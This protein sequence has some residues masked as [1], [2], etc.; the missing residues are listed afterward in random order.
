MNRLHLLALLSTMLAP[1]LTWAQT[2][3]APP[4][5][6]ATAK[7]DA[8]APSKELLTSTKPIDAEG[9]RQIA[10]FA[11]SRAELILTGDPAQVRQA[12]ADALGVLRQPITTPIFRRA[13]ADSLKP[14][15]GRIIATNDPYR[16][17]NILQIVQWTRTPESL[18]VLIQQS[19]PS[20]QKDTPTRIGASR[21]L[22][23]CVTGASLT[24]PQLESAARHIREAAEAETDWVVC[25]HELQALAAMVA[26]A[27]ES[28]FAP[29]VELARGEFLKSLHACAAKAAKPGGEDQVYALQRGLIMLRDMLL[30]TSKDQVDKKTRDD[31]REIAALAVE[32]SKQPANGGAADPRSQ[33]AAGA[34]IVAGVVDKLVGNP[35]V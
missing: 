22:P 16:I 35:G 12:A 17:N 27:Q 15:V 6:G 3:P 28:K 32:I 4:K 25:V 18:D 24:A 33:A 14:F 10:E 13:F 31:V 11:G 26:Y 9:Q 29:Q 8:K 30:K 23:F 21:L 5:S 2:P 34:A 1:S 19:T 20:V 7:S